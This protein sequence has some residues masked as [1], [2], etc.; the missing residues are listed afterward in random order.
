MTGE[1]SDFFFFFFF[2]EMTEFLVK[3]AHVAG[4]HGDGG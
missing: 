1:V 3:G 2:P 4:I